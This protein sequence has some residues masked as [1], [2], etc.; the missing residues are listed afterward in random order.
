MTELKEVFDMVT[1]QTEPDLDSWKKQEDRQRKV[2]R[3][4]KLGALALVAAV[5][6]VLGV[7]AWASQPGTGKVFVPQPPPTSPAVIGALAPDEQDVEIVGLDGSPQGIV[8]NL[9]EDAYGLSLSSDGSTIAFV[10]GEGLSETQIATIGIDGAGM[11]L[12][13]TAGIA[14]SMPAWSPDGTM[15]AFEGADAGLE[16][17]I[18]VMNA[19]GSDVRRITDDPA[20]DQYPQWSPD[21]S[22]IAYDNSGNRTESDPQFSSTTDIWTVPVTGG[23]PTRLTTAPGAD[24]HPSY[25]PDGT[26]IAYY[27]ADGDGIWVM[28]QDGTNPHPILNHAGFTPRWSPNGKMIAYTV[29]DDTYAPSVPFGG[30]ERS[31]ALVI[32]NVVNVRTGQ[33]YKVGDVGMATDLN[34]PQWLPD[35]NA[36]LIRRVGY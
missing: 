21:G 20:Y 25:S 7:F 30:T 33:H 36:L 26:Q 9:P 29:Y 22:T 19:D 4:R 18:Y 8:P 11:R 10:T 16:S 14:A 3:N 2:G 35:S 6:V 12:L 5:V 32:V 28:G 15:I 1:K 13:T 24:A 34:T 31:T 23:A 27:V 17:D